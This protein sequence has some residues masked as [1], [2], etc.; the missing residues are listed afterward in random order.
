MS[1]A[2]AFYTIDSVYTKVC[3]MLLEPK[4]FFPTKL[5]RM[6]FNADWQ[7]LGS[8][9]YQETPSPKNLQTFHRLRNKMNRYN[10]N[11]RLKSIIM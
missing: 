10:H 11:D 8:I 5:E 7:H 2:K 4:K 3:T 9:L 1:W 6:F